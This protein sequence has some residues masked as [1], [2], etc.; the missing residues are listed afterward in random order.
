MATYIILFQ[1]TQQGIQTIKQS[2]TRLN[3]LK[4]I[5]ESIGAELKG[6]YMTMGQYDGII[7]TEAP[8]HDTVAQITLMLTSRGNVRTESLRAFTEDEYRNLIAALPI[9]RPQID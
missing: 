9:A 2:P 6:F 8:D 4:Q 1:W 5:H 3:V 7:I